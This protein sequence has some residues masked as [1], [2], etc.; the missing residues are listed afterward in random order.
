MP[1]QHQV[2]R[3]HYG[4][5]L[6]YVGHPTRLQHRSPALVC[7]LRSTQVEGGTS[8]CQFSGGVK[9]NEQS[10]MQA[11]SYPAWR[12]LTRWELDPTRPAHDIH[13]N[14][15]SESDQELQT[16]GTF[17]HSCTDSRFCHELSFV[18]S[19][20]EP[21]AKDSFHIQSNNAQTLVAKVA[22]SAHALVSDKERSRL[23]LVRFP[24]RLRVNEGNYLL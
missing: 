20:W 11:C 2:S 13:A 16:F 19:L 8:Y 5:V 21:A 17:Q 1:S 23:S 22:Q 14:L 7:F 15:A 18:S 9:T 6:I 24:G 4:F 3:T 12:T 10:S